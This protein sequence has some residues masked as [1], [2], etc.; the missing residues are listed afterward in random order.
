MSVD[1]SAVKAKL[2]QERAARMQAEKEAAATKQELA[3]VKQEA[4]ADKQELA[5][6]KKQV[7]LL[8]AQLQA[9]TNEE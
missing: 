9:L 5:D 8:T 4:A 6:A 3:D 7:E 2:K 1:F